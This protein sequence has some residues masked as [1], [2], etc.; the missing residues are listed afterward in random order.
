MPG[1]AAGP[2]LLIS[3]DE[4]DGEECGAPEPDRAGDEHNDSAS[5]SS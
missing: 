4:P 1:R 2:A 5:G 3:E